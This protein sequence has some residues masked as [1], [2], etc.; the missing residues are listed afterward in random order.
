MGGE[1][2][3][4][5]LLGQGSAFIIRLPLVRADDAAG[6]SPQHRDAEGF[7]DG[8]VLVATPNPLAQSLLRAAL[9][10]EVRAVEVTGALDDA[11]RALA[12]RRAD[13]VLVDGET[14]G[15]GGRNGLAN[16]EKLVSC[17]GGARVAVLCAADAKL[18]D[19][20]ILAAGATTVLR[21]PVAA[22][23]LV[24]RL[25]ADWPAQARP[26]GRTRGAAA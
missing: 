22:A 10:P 17:S 13:L 25:K 3:A 1:L 26:A 2:T 8:V 7:A 4:E 11:L 24:A 5:S 23:E 12:V 14:L 9:Q 6:A 20:R 15:L 16:L 18:D 21:K 19:A